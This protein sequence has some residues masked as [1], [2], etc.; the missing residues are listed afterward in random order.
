MMPYKIIP[1]HGRCWHAPG[2]CK[3][4][5]KLAMDRWMRSAVGHSYRKRYS[6]NG[7]RPRGLRL[8]REPIRRASWRHMER[9][10]ARRAGI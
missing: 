7:K 3:S 10:E 4:G 9:V 5:D 8:D 2:R 6:L 1:G